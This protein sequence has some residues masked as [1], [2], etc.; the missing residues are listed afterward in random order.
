MKSSLSPDLIRFYEET[1]YYVSDDPPL[2]LKIGRQNDDARILLASFGVE[3]AAFIT[4]W[5]PHSQQLTEEQNADRQAGLLEAI[6][7]R[8]L[9]YFVGWGEHHEWREY[10]YLVLGIDL[11]QATLLGQQFEQNAIVW[12]DLEGVPRLI[13]L[14]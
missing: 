12:L 10:S 9:N 4:A 6:E 14:V 11:E 7:Q 2:L 3:T 13:N 8:R 1:D 5:N